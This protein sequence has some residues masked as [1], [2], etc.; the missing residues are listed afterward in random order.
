M[1][2]ALSYQDIVAI[3][4]LFDHQKWEIDESNSASLYN[5]YIHICKRLENDEREL[6]ISLSYQYKIITLNHYQELLASILSNIVRKHLGKKQTIYVYPIKKATDK[7]HIKSSDLVTYLCKS[8]KLKYSDAIESKKIITLGSMEQIAAKKKQIGNSLLL[9]IDDFIGSGRYASEVVEEISRLG[10]PKE[11][12]IVVTLYIT[13]AGIKKLR[14]KQCRLE[15]GDIVESVLERLTETEKKIIARIEKKIGVDENNAFGYGQSATLISLI[16]TPN[17]T[18]PMFWLSSGRV[19][20][21]PF[22]R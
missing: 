20:S 1:A 11:H 17:N 3:Q 4:N 21:P 13:K 18:L 7:D 15:Y 5:R 8:T 9:I 12:L 2:N 16:R 6:F 14:Q 19:S 10:I 22:P